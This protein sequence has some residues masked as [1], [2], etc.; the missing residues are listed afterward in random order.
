MTDL[1]LLECA[2]SVYDFLIDDVD[3][4]LNLTFNSFMQIPTF[5]KMNETLVKYHF[6][7]KSRVAD[8]TNFTLVLNYRWKIYEQ[9]DFCKLLEINP[10]HFFST[11]KSHD[12]YRII[13]RDLKL[14]LCL[15]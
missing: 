2:Q 1:E 10:K 13:I 8:M 15:S 11:T 14:K 3:I 9:N 7:K 5:S 12:F 4:K 6:C